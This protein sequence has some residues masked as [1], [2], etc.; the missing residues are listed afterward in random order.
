MDISVPDKASSSSAFSKGW[1]YDV[2]I[3]FRGEDTRKNFTGHLYEAL[4]R[5]GINA[6]IDEEELKK[7]EEL[8][9]EFERAIQGSKISIIV[10]SIRYANSSWCLEELVKIMECRRTLGQ[11]VLP[12]FYDV[13]PSHVRKQTDSFGQLFLEHIDEKKVE[14]WKEERWRTALTEASNLSGWDLRNTLG[15]IEAKFIKK[16]IEE[17]NRKLN[18]TYL[19]VAPYQ[20][21]LDSRVQDIS[22][23]LCIG[24]SDDVRVVGILGM[25][26]IGKTTIAKAIYNEFCERFEGKC[27]LEKVREKK[28][29]KLQKHLL[30]DILQMTKKE[31]SSVAAGTALVRERFR[32]LKVLVIVDDVDDVKQLR[33][34][35]GNCHSFRPGSRII[36]TTRNER[37]LKEF[38]VDEIYREKGMDQEEALELLSWHAFRS[39]CCPSQYLVL[40]REV[41]NYCGGL[42]L[43]LEVLGSTL[44]KR[45]EHDWRSILDELKMIPRGEIQAQL[46]IS[47]DGLNDNYKRRIFLDI[48]CF[49]IGM[50]KNDVMQILDGC[51]LYAT[52]GI[53]VLLDLCLVTIGRKNKIMMHDLLRD[54]GRDIVHAENPNFPGERSRLWRPEDV[55]DVLIDKSGTEKIEGLALNLPSLEET[56]FSTEAFRN[57]RLRLLQLN[58]VRLA[59]GYQCLSKNLRW[60]CWHGF[61]LEFI[62]I[63]LCQPN[64]VAIDMRYSSLKQVLCEYSGLL[65][66]L[67]ILNLSHS[68][69]LTQSPDF[70][71]FPNLEKLILKDCKRLA[72]VH[73]SIGDLKSLVLVNLEGC[74][75]LK[76]LPRSFYKLK[77]VKTLVLN[78]CSRFRS[79]SEHL[80]KMTS[81]VTLYADGTAIKKVPPSIVRLGK[82]ERLS[83]SYLKCLL[84][85]PSLRG[86]R[87]LTS[88]SLAGNNLEEVPNDIGSSLPSLCSLYLGDNNFWSLPSLSGLSKLHTLFLNGCRNL[89]EITDLPKRL[90]HLGMDDCSALERMPDFSGMSTYVNIGSPKLIEFPGVE[91]VLNSGHGI[92]MPIHNKVTDYLLKDSTL[93]GW[94]GGGGWM[95]LVGRQIPTWFNHV[96][97][98]TQVSFE[99]PKEIGCN[100]KALAV[101]VACV[102][103]D[104]AIS[105][106]DMWKSYVYVINR[107]KRTSFC[108][109]IGELGSIED[110]LGWEIYR[111]R[112]LSSIWKKAIRFWS[113]LLHIVQILW[114]RK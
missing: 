40:A 97:E 21:G 53:E 89:V 11:I 84:P 9:T 55:N 81:L 93:Q 8:T 24:D 76:A 95:D 112:K 80:G 51:G 66:K 73:K 111:G 58:Y 109:E 70:S 18:N 71:K 27:F 22:N 6:F 108:V 96:N 19:D 35:V 57:M 17:V 52:T 103:H 5:A 110:V 79:L 3:S 38:E 63:E 43:A 37:V 26:G 56:S 68:H 75:T 83:L 74:E 77:S 7:G 72:E 78:G 49:F 86:L 33:E 32:L 105:F 28:L 113:M 46:K 91:S 102:P 94:T 85:L 59:G 62:P 64:I 61:P 23:Y 4:T 99:V 48:A 31:V 10:F 98:G 1:L 67:K 92:D 2:F 16:I 87:S 104:D 34:L 44:F 45:S 14:R 50:D 20:V 47:Y 42:P 69:D 25:G 29:E 13:D 114:S 39:S 106:D 65:G 60:L 15:G 88:L 30:Y 41:V 107:T 90:E 101:C 100:A 82:L 54:M 36:I 12:I